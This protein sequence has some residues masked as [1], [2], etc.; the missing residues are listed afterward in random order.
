MPPL[1]ALYADLANLGKIF[2]VEPKARQ[3]TA[4]FQA[5]VAGVE[6]GAPARRPSV[7][8]YDSGQDKPF[9]I[10]R[11]AAPEQIIGKAKRAERD[12]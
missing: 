7:F 9:T 10:G 12:G 1:D 11:F 8:L 3:L 5:E 6:A 4:E 2:D